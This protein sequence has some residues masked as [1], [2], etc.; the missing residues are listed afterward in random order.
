M[1]I[2]RFATLFSS[3][4]FFLPK[5]LFVHLLFVYRLSQYAPTEEIETASWLGQNQLA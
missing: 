4:F 2:T 5:P 1:H 3:P